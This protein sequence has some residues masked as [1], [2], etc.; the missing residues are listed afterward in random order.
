VL[1]SVALVVV[2]SRE[3]VLNLAAVRYNDAEANAQSP[4]A[5][6]AL[7]VHLILSS[8]WTF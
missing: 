1:E 6:A 3:D 4:N 5:D 7:R 8:R 2:S